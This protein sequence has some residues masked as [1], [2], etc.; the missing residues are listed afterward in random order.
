MTTQPA[1]RSLSA[2]LFHR[3]ELALLVLMLIVLWWFARGLVPGAEGLAGRYT[4]PLQTI[5]ATQVPGYW[6]ACAKQKKSASAPVI[7]GPN[8]MPS[9]E[10]VTTGHCISMRAAFASE[11]EQTRNINLHAF[12]FLAGLGLLGWVSLLIARWRAALLLRLALCAGLWTALGV[13]LKVMPAQVVIWIATPVLGFLITEFALWKQ[14]GQR[15]WQSP[16]SVSAGPWLYPAWVLLTGMGLI[17]LL[18]VSARGD[19]KDMFQGLNQARAL[20]VAYY[21]FALMAVLAPWLLQVV[22]HLFERVQRI[23]I[24]WVL[25]AS[26]LSTASCLFLAL[27]VPHI[28]LLKKAA[29]RNAWLRWPEQHVTLTMLLLMVS[30]LAAVWIALLLWRRPVSGWAA[31][32]ADRL[33]EPRWSALSLVLAIIGVAV[34]ARVAGANEAG[35]G[36]IVRLVAWWVVAW[37][38]YRGVERVHKREHDRAQYIT[39]ILEFGVAVLAWC[40]ALFLIVSDQGQT[41]AAFFSALVPSTLIAMMLLFGHWT[42]R[43]GVMVDATGLPRRGFQQAAVLVLSSGV[44]FAIYAALVPAMMHTGWLGAHVAERFE[45]MSA[46]YASAQ[47]FLALLRWFADAGGWAGYGVGQVPWCGWLASLDGGC[48]R[49]GVPSEIESDYAFNGLGAVYG[50]PMALLLVAL[51]VAWLFRLARLPDGQ[52]QRAQS[53][54]A[55]RSWLLTWMALSL[56]VQAIMTVMGSTGLTL[57]TGITLPLLSFGAT[58]LYVVA[59]MAGLAMNRWED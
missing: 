35:A 12:K 41:M 24:G 29:K 11:Q 53:A 19:P 46:P 15:A 51:T 17:W 23:P 45:A 39:Q 43:R 57:M 16:V 4:Q 36:E 28:A 40:G 7:P 20:W 21:A 49:T 47:D 33:Q 48:A 27:Q 37:F 30:I 50:Y 54:M 3:G 18:D 38:C 9:A 6:K 42:T 1:S 25:T 34:A 56:T 5:E 10:A 55:Y 8:A 14:R 32:C 13:W 31:W 26:L 2:V 58:G 52:A 22:M 59:G 44:V